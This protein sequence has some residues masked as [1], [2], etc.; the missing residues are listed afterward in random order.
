MCI[1]SWCFLLLNLTFLNFKQAVSSEQLFWLTELHLL[2]FLSPHP[3]KKKKTAF[4]LRFLALLSFP[5]FMWIINY[6]CISILLSFHY[7]LSSFSL[8]WSLILEK[9]PG[10]P[11]W[12]F[13]GAFLL[14]A[15][16]Q[17]AVAL[18]TYP[19]LKFWYQSFLLCFP[20][21]NF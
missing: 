4:F 18:S 8:V 1:W 10:W 6:F 3:P 16:G 21:N 13:I 2:W 7:S 20:L 15:L 14:P 17:L 5:T 12:E 9:S 11:V 19:L